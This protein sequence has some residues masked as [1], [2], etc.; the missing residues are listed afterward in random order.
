MKIPGKKINH[1]EQLFL[2]VQHDWN[3]MQQKKNENFPISYLNWTKT[4]PQNWIN[5]CFSPGCKNQ[6]SLNHLLMKNG[7]VN[8]ITSGG[9]AMELTTSRKEENYYHFRRTGLAKLMAIHGFCGECD[10]QLF[11][12]IEGQYPVVP[13]N[14]K[15]GGKAALAYSL[16]PIVHEINKLLGIKEFRRRAPFLSENHQHCHSQSAVNEFFIAWLSRTAIAVQNEINSQSEINFHVRRLPRVEICASSIIIPP[17]E[18]CR[19]ENENNWMFNFDLMGLLSEKTNYVILNVFPQQSESVV[20]MSTLCKEEKSIKLLDDF[21]SMSEGELMVF[22]SNSLIND[23]EDWAISVEL[24]RKIQLHTNSKIDEIITKAKLKK[25]P[26]K[27]GINF[28]EI[29]NL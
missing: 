23:I 5:K 11:K 17:I 27:E 8:Q 13:T 12:G 26:P 4:R 20:I 25:I 24:L 22:I 9:H 16:R 1:I 6:T 2:H 15:E 14:D 18:Y 10:H 19:F 7:I 29:Q 3:P 21:R 28:F